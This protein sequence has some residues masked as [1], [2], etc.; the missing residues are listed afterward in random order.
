MPCWS[1][2][3][4]LEADA[5]V[6][7]PNNNCEGVIATADGSIY[8]RQ[9][10]PRWQTPSHFGLSCSGAQPCTLSVSPTAYQ[11]GYVRVGA[12]S[13]VDS[14]LAGFFG[15]GRLPPAADPRRIAARARTRPRPQPTRIQ[16]REVFRDTARITQGILEKLRN[17]R[18][19]RIVEAAADFLGEIAPRSG[20]FIIIVN[21]CVVD[22]VMPGCAVPVTDLGPA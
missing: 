21:P 16:L 11:W 4:L 6:P 3:R 13:D 18:A 5:A 12:G 14:Y 17:S 10:V 2:W 19:A 7:C 15:G 1:A 8:Q 20:F 22:P 9:L